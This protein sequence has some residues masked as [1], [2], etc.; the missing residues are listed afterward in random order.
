ISASISMIIHNA[1]SIN[2]QQ[3]LPFFLPNI[4]GLRNLIDLGHAS[5]STSTLRFVFIS[6]F[7]AAQSWNA[8][9][10][11][12]QTYRRAD[13]GPERP[14]WHDITNWTAVREACER[15][16][17]HI[18]VGTT[19]R[20]CAA[21]GL[22]VAALKSEKL[23]FIE[24]DTTQPDL[25]LGHSLYA[26]ISA[27]ISMIIHNAWSINL[28]QDLPFFLPNIVGLRNLIDLGHASSST[29]TLRF[30]FISSFFAAQSW[31]A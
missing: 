24:G 8:R 5:S 23:V 10:W 14:Q 29:S 22:D 28:Q 30:V 2:L 7:F 9:L 12:Q 4:V 27:S 17:V 31:N 21:K 3:D 1:W 11:R 15:S 20:Q 18:G 13:C 19:R 26:E 6:S 25:G 16:L